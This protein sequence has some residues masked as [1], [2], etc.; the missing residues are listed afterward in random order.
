[1]TRV[2]LKCKNLAKHFWAK[3]INTACYISNRLFLKPGTDA[4]PYEIWR[5]K[6]PILKYFRMF[7]SVCYIM[8]DREH[9]AKCD[10][11]C[12]EE[13]FLG[14]SYT[15]RAYKVYLRTKTIMESINV[16]VDDSVIPSALDVE[17]VDFFPPS[18]NDNGG[19]YGQSGEQLES[20]AESQSSLNQDSCI[21]FRDK[22]KWVEIV[23]KNIEDVNCLDALM[24]ERVLLEELSLLGKIWLLSTT[25]KQNCVSLST[26]KA[27]YVA[28]KSCCTQLMWMK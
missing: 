23:P 1:M 22:P 25:K 2:M 6:K 9:L 28:T 27:E 4:T 5:G 24:I 11:N 14:Y 17:Y 15:S 18:S 3:A 10:T 12:D 13:I 8:R 20:D 19:V 16:K 7:G 26:A 21:V